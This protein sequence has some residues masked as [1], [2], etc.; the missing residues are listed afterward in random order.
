[1]KLKITSKNP[2]WP[3]ADRLAIYKH[4]RGVEPRATELKSSALNHAAMLPP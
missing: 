1:M 3:E 4:S 2:N